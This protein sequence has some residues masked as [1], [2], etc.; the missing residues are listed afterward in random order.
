[1]MM[2]T[3]QAAP[4]AL[5]FPALAG[6]GRRIAAYLLDLLIAFSVLLL[7][8]IS[9]RVFRAVGVWT[10]DGTEDPVEIWRAL[11]V[12]AKLLVVSAYVLS[13]G[14]VYFILF[15]ASPWQASHV[16]QTP[17]EDLRDR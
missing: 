14:P 4:S 2:A 9:M 17:P 12:G 16:G 7:V 13:G 5:A 3:S 8:A 11:G 15:H 10:P 6:L 1:M